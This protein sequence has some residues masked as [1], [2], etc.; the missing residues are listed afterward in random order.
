QQRLGLR[1][2]A[3]QC[4]G[5]SFSTLSRLERGVAEPDLATIK[6]VPAWLDISASSLLMGQEP[7]RA[8]LRA[9]SQLQSAT[10]QAL[11]EAAIAAQKQYSSSH[12][13]DRASENLTRAI[14][15]RPYR[16]L[17]LGRR[18]FFAEQF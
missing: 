16:P 7:I 6:R 8:H 9:Q 12:T 13:A 2:A 3:Q 18:E 1:E 15:N 11:A 4:G 10:A 5:I 14:T 17:S